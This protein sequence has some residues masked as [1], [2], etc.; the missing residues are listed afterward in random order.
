M[1]VRGDR[2]VM[3]L[4]QPVRAKAAEQIPGGFVTRV[5][6]IDERIEQSLVS[7]RLLSLLGTFFGG[8]AL[9]LACIGRMA[10]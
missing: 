6:T 10:S 1:A 5:A 3:T 8:L 9:L 7:E 2:D 4:V